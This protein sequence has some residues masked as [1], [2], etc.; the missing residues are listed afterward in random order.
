[1][2]EIL[3]ANFR[4]GQKARAKKSKM[5]GLAKG[6]NLSHLISIIPSFH[7]I[8]Y[9]ISRKHANFSDKGPVKVVKLQPSSTLC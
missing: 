2:L 8:Y 4:K 5:F 9:K 1:M 3:F 7:D 6:A